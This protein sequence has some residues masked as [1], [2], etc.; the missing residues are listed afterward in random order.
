MIK[1]YQF[2][3]LLR[4]KPFNVASEGYFTTTSMGLSHVGA[5]KGI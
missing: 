1:M 2:L 3:S 4:I 5:I